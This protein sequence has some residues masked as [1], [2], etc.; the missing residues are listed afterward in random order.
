MDHE[1]N[2]VFR[3]RVRIR[4]GDLASTPDLGS[5]L[6]YNNLSL[7]YVRLGRLADALGAYRYLRQLDPWQ[8]DHYLNIAAMLATLGRDDEAIVTLHQVATLL[9]NHPEIVSRLVTLYGRSDAGRQAVAHDGA[10]RAR[11]MLD[12]PVVRRHR[13]EA[14]R[15]LVQVYTEAKAPTAAARARAEAATLCS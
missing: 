15:D 3:E 7:A 13:C 12:A 11:L 10:G 4:G 5:P 1:E 9:P 14:H 8:P 2:R 6:L